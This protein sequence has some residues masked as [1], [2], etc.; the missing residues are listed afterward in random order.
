M[1]SN[2]SNICMVEKKSKIRERKI[3]EAN[4]KQ[5]QKTFIIFVKSG[6]APLSFHINIQGAKSFWME[7]MLRKSTEHGGTVAFNGME[8]V[9]LLG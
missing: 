2:E 7:L 9:F 3:K 8:T 4:R 6:Q 5:Q 1:T